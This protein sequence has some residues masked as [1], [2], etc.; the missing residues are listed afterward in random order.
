MEIV[1]LHFRY[2]CLTLVEL[3]LSIVSSHEPSVSQDELIV[4]PCSG[5]R[6]CRSRR[7]QRYIFSSETAWPIKA[8]CLCGSSLGKANEILYRWYITHD[9]DGRHAHIWQKPFK[10]FSSR[11]RSP[12]ILKL[13]MYHW[14]LKLYKVY[15]NNDPGLTKTYLTANSNRA[16]YTFEWGKLL[17]SH[18]MGE[19]LQQRTI[20]TE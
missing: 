17:Q 2:F 3:K 4:Y 7:R 14:G 6:C 11:T 19:T 1:Q 9:Q 18:L 12:M 13:D 15:I 8:K 16:T 10:I 20:L 5:D